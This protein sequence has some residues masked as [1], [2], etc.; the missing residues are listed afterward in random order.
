LGTS[1]CFSIKPVLRKNKFNE[2]RLSPFYDE[3][4]K[5]AGICRPH[6]EARIQAARMGGFFVRAI[7]SHRH[8]GSS[9]EQQGRLRC[10]KQRL[11]QTA[12]C[13]FPTVST[14]VTAKN[15]KL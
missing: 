1:V 8:G 12:E 13:K 6:I 7:T 14:T 2:Y 3:E 11:G 5:K 4:P 15:I 9:T 10:A